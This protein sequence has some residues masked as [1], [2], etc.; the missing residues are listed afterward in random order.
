M[1]TCTVRLQDVLIA[2][3]I[4]RTYPQEAGEQLQVLHSLL[5][6]RVSQCQIKHV[7]HNVEN[8]VR[9]NPVQDGLISLTNHVH[10]Q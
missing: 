9:T 3:I 10:F 7:W 8:I 4:A 2:H 5:V 6:I 1:E